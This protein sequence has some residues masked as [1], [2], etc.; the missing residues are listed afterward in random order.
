MWLA[1]VLI[2]VCMSYVC[3]YLYLQHKDGRE[4]CQISL[5][6][7]LP[8]TNLQYIPLVHSLHPH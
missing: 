6:Q 8:V 7:T 3:G 2:Q 1:L 4:F 5:S